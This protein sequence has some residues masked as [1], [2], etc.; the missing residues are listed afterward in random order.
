MPLELPQLVWKYLVGLSPDRM[1][2][3]EIDGDSTEEFLRN[4]ENCNT[5]HE[6]DIFVHETLGH[7][8]LWP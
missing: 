1:D 4:I 5:P 3:C 6:F 2:L 7:G 8:A